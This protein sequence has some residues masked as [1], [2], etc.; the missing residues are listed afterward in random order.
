MLPTP[1][2]NQVDL[3]LPSAATVGPGFLL[4]FNDFSGTGGTN[5]IVITRDGTDT[6]GGA[7][8]KTI[9]MP[10]GYLWLISNGTNGWGV[11]SELLS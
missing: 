10:N 6:I 7:T 5:D 9:S 3:T 4:Y 8:S 2:S 11:I 1:S